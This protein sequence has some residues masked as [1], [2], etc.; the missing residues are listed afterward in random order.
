MVNDGFDRL[1]GRF[2]SLRRIEARF[3]SGKGAASLWIGAQAFSA[4]GEE[5]LRNRGWYFR[6]TAFRS[7][8]GGCL[9]CQGFDQKDAER[10]DIGRG[11][12]I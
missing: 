1:D 11:S 2:L 8:P 5:R 10:P 9:L 3:D 4:D 12:H 7:V 6:I